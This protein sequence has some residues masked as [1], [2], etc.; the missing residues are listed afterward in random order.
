MQSMESSFNIQNQVD[1]KQ[2][3]LTFLIKN[4]TEIGA[5]VKVIGG[6]E[7]LSFGHDYNEGEY[8]TNNGW[9]NFKSGGRMHAL[10]MNVEVISKLDQSGFKK[11]EGLGVVDNNPDRF[12]AGTESSAFKAMTS[13]VANARQ[14]ERNDDE[15]FLTDEAFALKYG[16]SKSN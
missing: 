5:D 16:Q 12:H 6:K 8:A 2:E 1:K 7:G 11:V 10:Y 3:A 14:M 9:V 4:A 13:Q 15:R